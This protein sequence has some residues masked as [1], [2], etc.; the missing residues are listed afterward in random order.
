MTAHLIALLTLIA[1]A[2]AAPDPAVAGP[3][4]RRTEDAAAAAKRS[5]DETE[6]LR[7]NQPAVHERR[8]L[9]RKH[10]D[11]LER[12][13]WGEEKSAHKA[14]DAA[15]DAERATRKSGEAGRERALRQR[16]LERDLRRRREI[17]D[18]RRRR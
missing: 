4:E 10:R 16:R 1:I 3:A 14:V 15:R 6:K 7:A 9:I 13:E 2:A 17:D 18:D 8:T 5:K 11:A 12:A